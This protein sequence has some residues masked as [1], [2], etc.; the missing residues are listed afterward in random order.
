MGHA[1]RLLQK[2]RI[3][4]SRNGCQLAEN[5]GIEGLTDPVQQIR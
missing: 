5:V 2:L 3:I 1:H 4:Q